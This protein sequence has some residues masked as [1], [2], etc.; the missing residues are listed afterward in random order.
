MKRLHVLVRL[1]NYWKNL[2]DIF[3]ILIRSFLIYRVKILLPLLDGFE[4]FV[5]FFMNEAIFVTLVSFSIKIREI[6]LHN[7]IFYNFPQEGTTIFYFCSF[8][9]LFIKKRRDAV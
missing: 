3:I 5:N 9:F 1:E 2:K 6:Y 8:L 4:L 7:V